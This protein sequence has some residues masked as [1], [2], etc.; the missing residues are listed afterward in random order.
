MMAMLCVLMVYQCQGLDCT[1]ILQETSTREMSEG[2]ALVFLTTYEFTMISKYRVQ[3]LKVVD[4]FRENLRLSQPGLPCSP[5]CP[6]ERF[7]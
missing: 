4:V 3:F 6:T 5:P 1:I 2:C 7:L